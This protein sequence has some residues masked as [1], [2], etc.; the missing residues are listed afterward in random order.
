M[1]RMALEKWLVHNNFTQV[2]AGK[3]SHRQFVLGTCKV[4]VPGHGPKD[5]SKKHMGKILRSLESV[6]FDCA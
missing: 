6:G 5:L 3:T 2:P 4:T 1:P